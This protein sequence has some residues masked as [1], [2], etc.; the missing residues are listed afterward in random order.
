V[1][2]EL[3]DALNATVLDKRFEAPEMLKAKV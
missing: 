2:G 1:C 3:L